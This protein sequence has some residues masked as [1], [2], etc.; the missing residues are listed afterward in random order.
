MNYGAH[1]WGQVSNSSVKRIIKL[2]D[3]SLR[4]INFAN[5]HEP[6]SKL[7]Q[8]SKILKFED[9]IRLNGYFHVH[10]S[11]NRKL[12]PSLQDKF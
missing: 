1:V 5:Y 10:D 11:I 8:S 4:I 3:K 6:P 2:Q 9:Q 12:P 7:Y